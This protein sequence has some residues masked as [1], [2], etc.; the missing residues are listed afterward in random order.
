MATWASLTAVYP[1]HTWIIHIKSCPRISLFS[2]TA[3][4]MLP[5]S[6]RKASM[7]RE[8]WHSCSENLYA[9]LSGKG[10]IKDL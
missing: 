1:K 3:V 7:R 8:R 6:Q 10:N 9:E 2:L 5:F 4:E